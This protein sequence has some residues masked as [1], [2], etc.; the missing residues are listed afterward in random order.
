VE[1]GVLLESCSLSFSYLVPGSPN[2]NLPSRGLFLGPEPNAL[3]KQ[4][5][6]S[7]E[8]RERESHAR[9]YP[10]IGFRKPENKKAKKADDGESSEPTNADDPQDA[11]EIA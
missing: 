8:R 9:N 3:K 2:D 5:I 10:L 4:V 6:E 7:E 11:K 1:V